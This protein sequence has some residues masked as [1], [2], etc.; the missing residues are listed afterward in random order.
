MSKIIGTWRLQSFELQLSNE[1]I[2]FPFGKEA[3][4]LLIYEP[5]GF[6]SGMISGEGRPNVSKP[7]TIGIPENERAAIANKFIAYA[8]RYIIERNNI[9]HK[10]EVSFIPNL[11]GESSHAGNFQVEDNK[12]LISSDISEKGKTASVITKW[13]KM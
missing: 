13:I 11:M 6:M 3:K 12:L 8:G 5:N 7:A 4:G 9:I 1:E 10:I 2:I